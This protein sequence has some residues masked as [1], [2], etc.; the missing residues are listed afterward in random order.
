MYNPIGKK[1]IKEE[2]SLKDYKSIVAKNLTVLRKN[3]GL[4]QV[5]LAEQFNYSDKA[6]SRWEHGDT[7]PDINILCQLCEFYGISMNDLV[8]EE[9]QI[10]EIDS[11]K[12][13]NMVKNNYKH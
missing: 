5:E 2:Q 8:N 1:K 3:K 7:L 11:V 13:K 9:C 10:K 4:T 6:V 12:E